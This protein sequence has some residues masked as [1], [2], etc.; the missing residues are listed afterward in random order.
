[1]R[2]TGNFIAIALAMAA[3][4]CSSSGP[5]ESTVLATSGPVTLTTQSG[6]LK[7]EIRTLPEPATRGNNQVELTVTGAIDG[8]PRDGLTIACKPWM[9]AMGHGTSIVP[10]FAPEMMG[11]YMISD[12]DLFMPGLWQLRLTISGPIEDYVAPEYEIQ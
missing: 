10:S 4:G 9:P 1:M 8:Q 5:A 12:V 2:T 7:V 3:A 11:K 6:Q